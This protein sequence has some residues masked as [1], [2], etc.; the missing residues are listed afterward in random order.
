METAQRSKRLALPMAT[1]LLG[2]RGASLP[3]A[4]R[5]AWVQMWTESHRTQEHPSQTDPRAA[6]WGAVASDCS[7]EK[8]GAQGVLGGGGDGHSPPDLSLQAAS[9]T[10]LS[11]L[12]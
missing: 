6:G 5:M 10:A 8:M 2:A 12:A 11:T 7:G 1:T 3:V 9:P 4:L